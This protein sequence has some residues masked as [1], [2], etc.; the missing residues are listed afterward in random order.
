MEAL[1]TQIK[2]LNLNNDE[3][4]KSF[5]IIHHL[6]DYVYSKEIVHSN[7]LADFLNPKSSHNCGNFF[8]INFLKTIKIEDSLISGEIEFNV[9]TEYPIEN[10]RRIDILI[11]WNNYAV[12]IENK[13]NNAIDQ[14]DQLKDYHSIHSVEAPDGDKK[15]FNVLKV[16][17]IPAD[18]NKRAP[19][20]DLEKELA[21][22]IVTIFPED[23]IK[24]LEDF[25]KS[26]MA[27]KACEDYISILQYINQ[28]NLGIMDA[29]KILNQ[30]GENLKEL[31]AVAYI[32]NS[33]DWAVAVLD[34]LR[35]NLL[36]INN[37][38][39]FIDHSIQFDILE[40]RHAEIYY[41]GYKFWVS[42]YFYKSHFCLWIA[43]KS[44]E[45][46]EISP[47]I[48]E[49]G[50]SHYSIEGSYHFFKKPDMFKYNFPDDAA[51]EKLT[52][53]ILSILKVSKK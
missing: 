8:L 11:T 16:V 53:D 40:K 29:E 15:S 33:S 49:L 22:K 37:R 12:I 24:W 4:A 42:V 17:Y 2:Q 48:K 51:F 1:I 27:K 5:G 7:I 38:K 34:K 31:I 3:I 10:R 43:D 47:V 13:L 50:F 36:N 28:T 14:V 20:Y 35:K 30:T 26:Q 25:P 23:L 44:T 39:K 46:N 45:E 6:Y 32:I 18:K 19:V 21:D 41:D 9:F 52:K